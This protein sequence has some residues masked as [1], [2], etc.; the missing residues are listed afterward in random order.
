M[1][2]KISKI[3][4]LGLFILSFFGIFSFAS[5]KTVNADGLDFNP[6]V[7]IPGADDFQHGTNKQLSRSTQ[8]IADYMK[9]LYNWGIGIVGVLAGVV[10]IIAG[11]MWLTAGGNNTQVE[12]AKKWIG[13]ALSGLVLA[14]G[15]YFIL[16]QIN[17]ELVK[18]RYYTLP[19]VDVGGEGTSAFV[20]NMQKTCSWRS[21]RK[22]GV[23]SDCPP[24][25][26]DVTKT[27]SEYCGGLSS[28]SGGREDG[29]SVYVEMG[30]IKTEYLCCCS[31]NQNEEE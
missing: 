20:E 13:G 18:F 30:G 5:I 27:N 23:G 6:N 21:G 16:F 8:P 24:E 3:I 9:A 12:A 14:L 4:I 26:V 1:N 2:K 17:P 28:L 29:G 22:L 15:S 19:G 11:M 25:T 7:S 31:K 10:L